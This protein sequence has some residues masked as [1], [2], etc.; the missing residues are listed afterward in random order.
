MAYFGA[1]VSHA[2]LL[3]VATALYWEISIT[4]GVFAVAVL[5]APLLLLLERRSD[6]STDTLLGILAHGMLALGL[7]VA[8][9][10]PGLRADL[11]SYLFGDVLSVSRVDIVVIYIGGV[12]ILAVLAMIWRALLAATL[13]SDLAKAENLQP[14]RA[15]FIFTILIAAVVAI[16]MKIIGI[17]LIVSLLIIPA[18]AARSL[19]RTPEQMA[20]L[21]ALM[22]GLAVVG[23]LLAS[24]WLNTQSGPSVVVAALALFLLSLLARLRHA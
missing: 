6:L 8:A 19:A 12:L 13:S 22:G 10:V 21:A 2:A 7:V 9:F 18:A 16:A 14:E 5:L 24:L 3:G 20:I 23:G 4:I 1:T 11:M 15:R 17:L